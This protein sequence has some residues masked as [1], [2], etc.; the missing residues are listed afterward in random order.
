MQRR[1]IICDSD[2][3]TGCRLCE[4]LCPDFAILV[5]DTW[6]APGAE[7]VEATQAGHAAP[8]AGLAATSGGRDAR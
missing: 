6:G 4:L 2:A 1:L 5:H 7:A 3:C 8:P